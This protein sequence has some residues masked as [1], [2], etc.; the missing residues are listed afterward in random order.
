MQ[1]G[2]LFELKN[3]TQRRPTPQQCLN[4]GHASG[5]NLMIANALG[6][7]VNSLARNEESTK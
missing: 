2:T 3:A 7:P 5:V 6:N 4:S 1:A